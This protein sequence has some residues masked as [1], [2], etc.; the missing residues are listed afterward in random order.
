MYIA[1]KIGKTIININSELL[2]FRYLRFDT[3]NE[4]ITA[5]ID[6]DNWC[7][8]PLDSKRQKHR[9]TLRKPSLFWLSRGHDPVYV[10]IDRRNE[11]RIDFALI[12]RHLNLEKIKKLH[13]W[14]DRFI[15]WREAK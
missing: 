12:T 9:K 13:A 5:S 4:V 6:G 2:L 3:I 15:K 1:A 10:T 8:Y 11:V 7:E 14:L